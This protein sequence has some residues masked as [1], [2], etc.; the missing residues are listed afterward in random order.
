MRTEQGWVTEFKRLGALWKHD[1]D[2]RRPYALFRSGLISDEATNCRLIAQRPQ[3]LEEAAQDLVGIM[4]M[5][6]QDPDQIVV[7]GPAM[8]SIVL[9]YEIAGQLGVRFWY[10]EKTRGEKMQLAGGLAVKGD[11]YFIVCDDTITTGGSCLK[12]IA[13]LRDLGIKQNQVAPFF[14]ALVN[15]SGKEHIH[16]RTI[17]SLI[18]RKIIMWER[19]RNPFTKGGEEIL[20]PISPKDNWGSL[21]AVY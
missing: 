21:N 11:E 19:G 6:E 7:I 15:Q 18:S 10:S 9:A 13:G 17:I 5:I 4:P 8:G 12:T 2:K 16:N 3:L 20:E 1:G 14:L